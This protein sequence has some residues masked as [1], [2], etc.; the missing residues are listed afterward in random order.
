MLAT[1]GAEAD[2]PQTLDVLAYLVK[3]RKLTQSEFNAA[4][5]YCRMD[6][7]ARAVIDARLEGADLNIIRNLLISG[8]S[9][10]QAV[11]S[12]IPGYPNVVMYRMQAALVELADAMRQ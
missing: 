8:S 2:E 9:V 5:T 12:A 11:T 4:L 3:R 7:V 6:E 10:T 1:F